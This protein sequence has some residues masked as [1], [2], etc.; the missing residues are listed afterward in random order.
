MPLKDEPLLGYQFDPDTQKGNEAVP[1]QRRI[2]C[3]VKSEPY[4]V[5]CTQG[6]GQPYG[7]LVAFA[8]SDDLKYAVFATTKATRKYR[9]L[10]ECSHV[11]LVIDTRSRFPGDLMKVEAVT[12]TGRA[13]QLK[14]EENKEQWFNLL[15][16]KH[17]HLEFFFKSSSTA[18]FRINIFRYFHVSRFQEVRQWI[19]EADG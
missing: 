8:I 4:G 9:L 3:L 18:L 5:L 15:I 13:M 16:E 10:C 7:S 19:P 11:A 17:P 6:Y 14:E 12:A 1:L 2:W